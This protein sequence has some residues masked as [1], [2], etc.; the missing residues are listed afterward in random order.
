MCEPE[1][2][3][4][5]VCSRAVIGI[6]GALLVEKLCILTFVCPAAL[7]LKFNPTVKAL[8]R[9]LTSKDQ[10]RD[11]TCELASSVC[12]SF[13]MMLIAGFFVPLIFP[14]VATSLLANAAVIQYAIT[15]L[16]APITTSRI[17]VKGTCWVS[18]F[19]FLMALVW[20]FW[21][22]DLHGKWLVATV[23]PICTFSAPHF[24]PVARFVRNEQPT[25]SSDKQLEIERG[26]GGNIYVMMVD[27]PND[28]K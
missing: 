12:F 13:E 9:R 4:T 16:D 2:S 26:D 5:A 23:T 22:C 1:Y 7:L 8:I 17:N 24:M 19:M 25:S 14:L 11:V 21:E 18:L 27:E 3:R 10:N 28:S 6:T 15:Y 20:L